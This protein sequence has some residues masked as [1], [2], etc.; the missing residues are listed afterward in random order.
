MDNKF[1]DF[2]QY[3]EERKGQEKPFVIK[4]FG[5]E[6]LIPNDIPFDIV[7]EITRAHKENQ[8]EM[9]ENQLLKMSHTLFGEETFNKWLK[10]G[11]GLKGIMVLTEK[12]M[13]IY[14]KNASNQSQEI[15]KR[16]EKKTP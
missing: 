11:I 15:A 10:K 13:E 14:M 8:T 12:V 6:H 9:T 5:E 3:M 16:E 2:D 4:A 1:F 7:L